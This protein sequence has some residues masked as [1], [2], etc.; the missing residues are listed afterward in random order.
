[1][2]IKNVQFRNV[3]SFGGQLQSAGGHV[4]DRPGSVPMEVELDDEQRFFKLSKNV[5]G[6]ATVR[7]VPMENVASFEPMPEVKPAVK[8]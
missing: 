7:F 1:M 3:V 6:V 2:K 8:K 5:N 4:G